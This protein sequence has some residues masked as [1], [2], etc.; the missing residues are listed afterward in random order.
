MTVTS[1]RS[2]SRSFYYHSHNTQSFLLLFVCPSHNPQSFL[3]LFVCV[4]ACK[5][6]SPAMVLVVLTIRRQQLLLQRQV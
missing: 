1:R 4:Y 5:L 2:T 6:T 3:L